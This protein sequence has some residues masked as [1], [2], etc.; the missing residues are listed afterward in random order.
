MYRST[1][2]FELVSLVEPRSF[3]NDILPDLEEV[4]FCENVIVLFPVGLFSNL[5]ALG[6]NLVTEKIFTSYSNNIQDILQVIYRL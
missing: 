1:D 5:G 2:S 3:E 6:V 4:E